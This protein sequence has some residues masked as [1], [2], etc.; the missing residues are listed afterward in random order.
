M[1][2]LQLNWIQGQLKCDSCYVSYVGPLLQAVPSKVSIKEKVYREAQK[3]VFHF[4]YLIDIQAMFHPTLSDGKLLHKLVFSFDDCTVHE[5]EKHYMLLSDYLWRTIAALA[6]R[7]AF[8]LQNAQVDDNLPAPQ[9][10]APKKQ[11]I[12]DPTLDLLETLIT[13]APSVVIAND[14]SVTPFQVVQKKSNFII[15]SQGKIRQSLKTQLFGGIAN[16][17]MT[18]Y[19]VSPKLQVLFLD[20]SH[21]VVGWNAIL[22]Y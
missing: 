20:V 6:E 22:D 17:H 11:R 18:T 8:K 13:T 16:T 21:P 5:K 7:V 1:L 14:S 10:P 19:L 15:I 12:E 4:S 2:W 3:N 9:V